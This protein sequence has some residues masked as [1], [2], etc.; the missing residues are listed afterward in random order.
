MAEGY[1]KPDKKLVDTP[2]EE[3]CGNPND[4]AGV[5]V[6]HG[7]EPVTGADYK[8]SG[9]VQTVTYVTDSK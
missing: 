7:G 5:G 1:T 4:Q 3:L 8:E 2:V 6:T 9:G